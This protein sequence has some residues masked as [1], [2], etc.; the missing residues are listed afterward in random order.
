MKHLATCIVLLMAVTATAQQ[1]AKVLFIGNSYTYV[2]DLPTLTKNVAL[3]TGDTL[4][5]DSNTPGGS[6]FQMH[7]TNA[8]TTGKISQGG[9]DYVVL[10]EQSQLP[11]F[12]PNQVNVEVFPYATQLDSLINATNTC[13]ETMFY[14]TWGRKNGD[15]SNCGSWPP[16]CT[17]GGMDSMLRLNYM[18][19]AADNHAVVSPVGAVWHWLRTN[20][21][22]MELY[23]A[24]ESHPSPAGSYAA[25]CSFYA[26]IFRKDPTLITYNFTIPDT[27]AIKI[28][29]AAKA[30]VFDSLLT[31]HVGEYD[32]VADFSF[33]LAGSTTVQCANQSINADNYLWQFGDGD[34]SSLPN[35]AHNYTAAGSYTITLIA[36]TCNRTDTFQQVALIDPLN[37]VSSLNY[38]NLTLSPNPVCDLLEIQLKGINFPNAS[39]GIYNLQGELVLSKALIKQSEA[40]EMSLLPAGVYAA[41]VRSDSALVGRQLLVK[42]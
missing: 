1:T 4:I 15:A 9:W 40:L 28:R 17:Y 29:N 16:V 12:P 38:A 21:P 7:T 25:A 14:M 6:T 26:A 13:A 11:S 33:Q 31:W 34:T 10:Q 23:N 35:P 5:F 24:D 30:V 18:Q 19:M 32:P 22:G 41:V 20:Y 42:Q 27:D 39:L 36:S 8:N 37:G 2:N 3:S